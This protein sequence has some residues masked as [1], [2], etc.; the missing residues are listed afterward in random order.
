[1][2]SDSSIED[3]TVRVAQAWKVGLKDQKNGAVLFVFSQD[4]KLYIQVGYGLEGVL[5][6]AL[7]KQIIENEITP[8]FR[9]GDFDGGLEAGV[10]A[11]IAATRGEYKGT[12]RT[13]AERNRAGRDNNGVS[14][15][16]MIIVV[17]VILFSVI[18]RFARGSTLDS[19]R[20][21]VSPWIWAG[22]LSGGGGRWWQ[23]G[24]G[25]PV[26]AVV[27]WWRQFFRRWRQLRRR[28]RGREL[29]I[30]SFWSA[31]PKIDHAQV[32]A[33]I[34]AAE[35]LTSGEIRVF[36]SH[37][38]A[39]DALHAAQHQFEKLGM[40]ATPHRNGVLIFLAP[41]SRTYAVIGDT[42]VHEKCGD[43]FWRLLAAAMG[44]S[45][46]AR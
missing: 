17:M 32:T 19:S 8:H 39:P 45:F 18:S 34:A 28:W 1:M 33:A 29:V 16:V 35:Q 4:R 11:L 41:R 36:I 20:G 26:E 23:S 2:Q 15:V 38:K 5:P 24:G 9:Q 12:G 40:T 30:M 22:L 31:T 10:Y 43:A 14:G 13:V 25:S 27:G 37:R 42:A 46:Q 44:N 3:Y 6:D 21:R 7:C